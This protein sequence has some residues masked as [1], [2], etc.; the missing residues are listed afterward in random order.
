MSKLFNLIQDF[1]S[2]KVDFGEFGVLVRDE[3]GNLAP[4][5]QAY[6]D[7]LKVEVQG[8]QEDFWNWKEAEAFAT[9]GEAI[10]KPQ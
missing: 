8:L 5:D 2:P 10:L 3:S 7:D 1:F 9:Y 6:M 4:M